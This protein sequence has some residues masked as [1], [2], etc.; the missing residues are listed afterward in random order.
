MI[1]WRQGVMRMLRI[2]GLF[3]LMLGLAMPAWAQGEP[4]AAERAFTQCGAIADPAERL[5]CYDSAQP[6]PPTA[7]PAKRDSAPS[8]YPEF[9]HAAPLPA[10]PPSNTASGGN[11]FGASA[12][13]GKLIAAVASYSLSPS[14]RFT[15][16]L[17]NGQIWRQVDSDDGV[18]SS[19]VRDAIW[20]RFPRDFFGATT[21]SS[22]P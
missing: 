15:I 1:F 19:S 21:S 7:I 12:R 18:A 9:N 22:T 8:H 20:W 10:N 4:G 17:D 6:R 14:G 3:G 13:G 2:S 11:G 5:A 16:V